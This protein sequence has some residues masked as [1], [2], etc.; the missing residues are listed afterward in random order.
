MVGAA[1]EHRA[2][3]NHLVQRHRVRS[4]SIPKLKHVLQSSLFVLP[5][6]PSCSRQ[7]R[8][9]LD[10][11]INDILAPN[12]QWHAGR[13]AAA[14]RTA[15]IS[16]LWALISSDI[17]SAKQVRTA[18]TTP[19]VCPCVYHGT[20]QNCVIQSAQKALK[21]WSLWGQIR[22]GPKSL[23]LVLTSPWKIWDLVYKLS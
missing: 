11:V 8:G 15:A 16:C 21:G 14:I 18:V 5:H 22:A 19:V 17:L 1:L 4:S 3:W 7:F 12:L 23:A 20:L 2:P 10:M 9:Y 13:T 6:L